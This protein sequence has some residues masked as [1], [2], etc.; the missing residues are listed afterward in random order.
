[1]TEVLALG[2]SVFDDITTPRISR[3]SSLASK[4][5]LSISP[6]YTRVDRCHVDIAA[7]DE[8][9][10]PWE[11]DPENEHVVIVRKELSTPE[12]QRLFD[13]TDRL[14]AQHR[15]QQ[16]SRVLRLEQERPSEFPFIRRRSESEH[17][18]GLKRPRDARRPVQS[19]QRSWSPPPPELDKQLVRVPVN[20]PPQPDTSPSVTRLRKMQ[21]QDRV[22][23]R[24]AETRN[25]RESLR[26][27]DCGPQESGLPGQGR[28]RLVKPPTQSYPPVS[29][30]RLPRQPDTDVYGRVMATAPGRSSDL[31][32][33]ASTPR[34]SVDRKASL[35]NLGRKRSTV[36][37]QAWGGTE[38]PQQSDA[39]D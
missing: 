7:L 6:N 18:S 19:Q 36:A 8:L 21:R 31:G 27:R 28:T 25:S 9:R 13:T 16:Q 15:Q 4:S 12:Q 30:H 24:A 17:E 37:Q 32:A 11:L 35:P 10:L 3:R 38:S 29:L 2:M 23:E 1:M 5:T 39:E 22:E 34:T 14:R 33:A 20:R 26:I